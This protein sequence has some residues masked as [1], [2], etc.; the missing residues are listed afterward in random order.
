MSIKITVSDTVRFKVAGTIADASGP[1]PFDF[2]LVARRLDAE[3]LRVR[4]DDSDTS[5]VD[6]LAEVVTGWQGVKGDAG[7]LPY[8]PDALRQLLQI[9]GLAALS[10][11]SYLADVGAKAKN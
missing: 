6:F 5:I 10:M 7:E 1:Q 4:L 8:S 11:R 2:S 3:Q 9:P